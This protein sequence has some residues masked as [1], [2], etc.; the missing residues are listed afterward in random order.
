M[1]QSHCTKFVDKEM[2]I[3]QSMDSLLHNLFGVSVDM[4]LFLFL[5]YVFGCSC[6]SQL[7]TNRSSVQNIDSMA[8]RYEL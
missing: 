7:V 8:M 4:I 5:L 1:N 3:D 2:A 6:D